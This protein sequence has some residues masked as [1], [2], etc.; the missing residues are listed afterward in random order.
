MGLLCKY[1]PKCF[2]K[3]I[4][5]TGKPWRRRRETANDTQ[6]FNSICLEMSIRE[7]QRGLN[8]NELKHEL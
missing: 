7:K 5:N 1:K 6:S 3:H 2:Y 8:E 4:D